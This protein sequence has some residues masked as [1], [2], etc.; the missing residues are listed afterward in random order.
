MRQIALPLILA[1]LI[2]EMRWI[3]AFSMPEVSDSPMLAQQADDL[4]ITKEIFE[5]FQLSGTGPYVETARVG[6]VGDGRSDGH[7]GVQQPPAG[8]QT[9]GAVFRVESGAVRA[10][11]HPRYSMA[12]GHSGA[13]D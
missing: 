2:A 9:G 1:N 7:A 11:I 6:G 13:T 10:T 8:E 3:F 5:L 4:P 12:T